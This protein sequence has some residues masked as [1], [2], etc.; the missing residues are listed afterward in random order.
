MTGRIQVLFQQNES[1]NARRVQTLVG[2]VIAWAVSTLAFWFWLGP[3]SS[4]AIAIAWVWQLEKSEPPR[5]IQYWQVVVAEAS[6]I[7]CLLCCSYWLIFYVLEYQLMICHSPPA[8]PHHLPFWHSCA[9]F[10]G[11]F[12]Y[13][14]AKCCFWSVYLCLLGFAT[15]FK[16][17]K[18]LFLWQSFANGWDTVEKP[19][20]VAPAVLVF[21]ADELH[22]MDAW[23]IK[24]SDRFVSRAKSFELVS[25]RVRAPDARWSVE[26]FFR[27]I[28]CFLVFQ[29]LDPPPPHGDAV[30]VGNQHMEL[31]LAGAL[32]ASVYGNKLLRGGIIRFSETHLPFLYL[33]SGISA[34]IHF[35]VERANFW[36]RYKGD[37]FVTVILCTLDLLVLSLAF[38]QGVLGS[39]LRSIAPERFHWLLRDLYGLLC[40]LF[41]KMGSIFFD[42]VLAFFLQPLK[43]FLDPLQAWI[44]YADEHYTYV[45]A[46]MNALLNLMCTLFMPL[47]NRVSK[48][49]SWLL[50]MATYLCDLKFSRFLVD[51]GYSV[52]C[53][54]FSMASYLYNT[55]WT[56]LYSVG[57]GVWKAGAGVVGAFS[58]LFRRLKNKAVMRLKY[59]RV[60]ASA[61]CQ[62]INRIVPEFLWRLVDIAVKGSRAAFVKVLLT[63]SPR[64]GS[65][66]SGLGYRRLCPRRDAGRRHLSFDY[67][68]DVADKLGPKF[69]ALR[70]NWLSGGGISSSQSNDPQHP[71]SDSSTRLSFS[72]SSTLSSLSRSEFR[73]EDRRGAADHESSESDEETPLS[74]SSTES[75]RV[76]MVEELQHQLRQARS[77]LQRAR[78]EMSKQKEAHAM[79]MREKE[80]EL[81]RARAGQEAN[82]SI[83]VRTLVLG[84][85]HETGSGDR[86][87]SYRRKK[88]S[89]KEGGAAAT[90]LPVVSSDKK[91]K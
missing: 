42:Y 51:A 13:E 79:E 70:N 89:S 68:R 14:W 63:I 64:I 6:C 90:K 73:G 46:R 57:T 43:W 69:T 44:V 15:G 33:L 52:V 31:F 88:R 37:P 21:E 74:R 19:P 76:E 47:W 28:L 34:L 5:Q 77:D 18:T 66:L 62:L 12:V 82:E 35:T 4:F 83:N 3:V 45:R 11:D 10:A 25:S 71:P 30:F 59:P 39:S 17:K 48:F 7:W 58:Q 49:R 75:P 36:E 53:A 29:E 38:V 2:N 65:V 23:K 22:F 56:P 8:E 60:L 41:S 78:L 81:Q 86:G 87:G 61:A 16:E 1:W 72:D 84:K 50:W 24:Y 54:F 32:P 91:K 9:C 85:A 26:T 27:K 55:F 20:V 40:G 67:W 80:V